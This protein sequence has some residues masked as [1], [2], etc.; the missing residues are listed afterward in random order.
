MSRDITYFRPTGR[1]DT[2]T[3]PQW[4]EQLLR[5]IDRG[6]S[7]ILFDCSRLSYVSSAGLKLVIV[8]AK[9]MRAAG[10]KIVFCC[11]NRQIN[12]VFQVTGFATFLEITQS[13]SEGVEKL[14]GV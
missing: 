4:E 1:L 11:I 13:E 12:S 5:L 8:A 2:A 6:A 14:R 7:R 9:R 10:G 3:S